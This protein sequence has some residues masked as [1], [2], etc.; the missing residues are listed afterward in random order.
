MNLVQI[1]LLNFIINIIKIETSHIHRDINASEASIIHEII[2]EFRNKRDST[3]IKTEKKDPLTTPPRSLN[4]IQNP[5]EPLKH[6]DREIHESDI[7][8]YCVKHDRIHAYKVPKFMITEEKFSCHE[9]YIEIHYEYYDDSKITLNMKK[10]FISNDS[11]CIFERQEPNL[12]CKK[13][14]R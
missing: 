2:A 3:V 4:D 9:K 6:Y 10:G 8:K 11:N 5:P 12:N 14:K 1:L 7:L 13:I